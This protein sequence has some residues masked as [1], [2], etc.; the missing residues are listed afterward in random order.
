MKQI[1]YI[2]TINILAFCLY[3]CSEYDTFE[4]PDQTFTGTVIDKNTGKPLETETGGYRIRMEELSWSENPTPWYIP[5]MQDGTFQNTKVFKGHYRVTP[6]EG[7]YYPIEGKEIT[8]EGGKTNIKFEVEPFLNIE[9]LSVKV[10]DKNITT[11]F[12]ITRSSEGF[13]ITDAKLFLS[14]TELCNNGAYL[15]INKAGQQL[16]PSIDFKSTPDEEVLSTIHTL[17][18][19]GVDKGRT[20]SLRVGARSNDNIQKKYNYTNI[21]KVEV[22]E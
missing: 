6:V 17:T 9:L 20:Y 10:E 19:V 15:N 1:I 4:A 7:P 16:S 14:A 18:A 21:E 13:K 12:K 22:P 2:I 11:T 8:V 3:S 5:S